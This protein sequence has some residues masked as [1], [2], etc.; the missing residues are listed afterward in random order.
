MIEIQII[1][2]ILKKKSLAILFNN[3][4]GD[5]YFVTYKDEM[6]YIL[7]HYEKYNTV[8]DKETFLSKFNDFDIIEVSESEKYLI[9]TLQEQHMYHKL[10]PFVHELAEHVTDDATKAVEF[11]LSQTDNIKRLSAQYKEGYDIIK[12]SHDRKEEYKFRNE[13]EGLLGITTGIKELDEITHGWLKE[14]FIVILGRTNEGKTWVLLFFLVSAW[15]ADVP[16]LLYSGEM[17]ETLVGFRFDTLKGH[18][19]NRALMSGEDDLGEERTKEDYYKYINDISMSKTPFIV[20]TPKHLGGRRLSVPKLHQLIEQYNPGIIGIDQISLMEDYRREKGD[21]KRIQ[22]GNI[23]EDL[24]LTSEKYEIPILA[25]AQANREA[26]KD[27]KNKEEAPQIEHI[28]ESDAIAQ[29][30]TRVLSLRNID[31]TMKFA[32]VKNRYGENNKELLLIWDINKGI[33]KPFLSVDTDAESG[34][35]KG[36]E[37]LTGEDLF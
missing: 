34:D 32:I 27:K 9:E 20:I 25:P 5:D 13:V 6:R 26:K 24:F 22:Y 30:A 17:S 16:V 29:N 33:V 37:Q 3:N 23:S 35:V 8:P 7:E 28:S 10:V 18:F 11:L 14:D 1:N 21:P 15:L 12:N 19:S 31:V 4:I 2:H 36:T